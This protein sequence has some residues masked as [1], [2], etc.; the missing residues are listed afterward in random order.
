V[1][2]ADEMLI[3]GCCEA[4]TYRQSGRSPHSPAEGPL[5]RALW[6]T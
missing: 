4:W 1:F 6:H 5:V 2:S 3:K